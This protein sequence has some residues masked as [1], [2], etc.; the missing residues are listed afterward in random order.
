M[1]FGAKN[2]KKATQFYWFANYY[3]TCMGALLLIE[4]FATAINIANRFC[5]EIVDFFL[6]LL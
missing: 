3:Y 5:N 4:H 6:F 2:V 1:I